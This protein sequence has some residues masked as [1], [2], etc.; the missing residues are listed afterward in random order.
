MSLHTSFRDHVIQEWGYAPTLRCIKGDVLAGRASLMASLTLT[1]YVL[2]IA[3][4]LDDVAAQ[5][6]NNLF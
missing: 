1:W 5:P 6:V 2:A 4:R 3:I